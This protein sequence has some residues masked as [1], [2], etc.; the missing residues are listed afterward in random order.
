MNEVSLHDLI[1]EIH[2]LDR[3]LQTLE[4]KY[5]LLSEDFYQ[6]YEA[7][8]LRDEE[9]DEIDEF[10][11]W[12]AMYRMRTRRIAQYV[13]AKNSLL[14]SHSQANGVILKPHPAIP[15]LA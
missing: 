1:I 13:Q 5:S 8:R 7:G 14:V 10:G 3:K 2:A 9:L 11:Q 6:L 4:E 15:E 12:A